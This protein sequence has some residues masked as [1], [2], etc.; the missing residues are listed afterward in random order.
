MTNNAHEISTPAASQ[1]T[2][3]MR[4]LEKL[5]GP[6]TLVQGRFVWVHVG[7]VPAKLGKNVIVTPV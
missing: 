2:Q 3:S 6:A 4:R 7:P 5:L 1:T